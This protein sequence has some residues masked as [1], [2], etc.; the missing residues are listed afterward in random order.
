VFA[1]LL[2]SALALGTGLLAS[3]SFTDGALLA[4]R[5]AAQITGWLLLASPVL[6]FA[7][8]QR[9][10]A[11]LTAAGIAFTTGAAILYVAYFEWSSE[12]PV[13]RAGPVD[14]APAFA[15]LPAP[16]PV[17]AKAQSADFDVHT[18]AA[19]RTASSKRVPAPSVAVTVPASIPAARESGCGAELGLRW[20]VC[21]EK[22]RLERCAGRPGDPACPS[23]IPE[24][25]PH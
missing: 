22:A 16:A 17:A 3:A 11:E 15:G 10:F 12:S 5:T 25:Q 21:E 23:A 19:G 7:R 14:I 1:I 8:L 6:A 24:S 9:R 18:A 2:A 20:I 4:S 13:P